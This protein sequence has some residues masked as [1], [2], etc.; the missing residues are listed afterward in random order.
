MRVLVSDALSEQ[1]LAI[2][3]QTPG[4]TID[5]RPG[6]KEAELAEAIAGA[7]G[8]VIRSGSKVTARVIAAADQLKVIGRAGIGVDNV[9]VPAASK[10]GIVVMNTPT[11]NAV[12]TAEHA[13]ALLM[14][15]A[16]HVPQASALLKAGKWE[17][18]KFEGRELAGK[19]LGVV[20]LG[21]IGRIVADR[22]R[23]LS[24]KVIGFDPMVTADRAAQLGVELCSLDDIFARADAI[25]VHT[26]LTAQTRGLVNEEMLPRLKKG[27]LLV[28]AARGGIYDEAALLK[29]L[30]SGQI[31]GVALDVFV[32]EPPPAD[33]P[34]LLHDRVIA[35]PHLGAST[36]EAQDRVALEIAE[37]VVMYLTTGEIKNAVNTPSVAGEIALKQKPYLDLAERLGSFLAQVEPSLSPQA[38]EVECS[39]Q[40]AELGMKGISAAAVAGCLTRYLESAMNRVSAPVAAK[41]RGI[42]VR[43]LAS[44]APNEKYASLVVLRVIAADGTAHSVA[45]ALGTD[46]SPRL[47][48][49]DDSEVEAHL[50]GPTLVIRS[51]NKPGVIGFIGT[52]LGAASVNVSRVHLGVASS[53]GAVSVW[54]LDT[55]APASAVDEL[56]RSPNVRS[57]VA[58]RV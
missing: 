7:D 42:T 6:L 1:G 41:E 33:H 4:A 58:I 45:G 32:E 16:R 8:L 20:G 27:V 11:G 23:G 14:A 53:E 49:W 36:K 43:E 44:S 17:K 35:T 10:R 9:D 18:K 19:T 54:N 15:L 34:L 25:T 3:R 40:P 38:V 37:Q 47:L 29:G 39:G 5:Y 51:V 56:R 2:L 31:G 46:G 21:N 28:N 24:M 52:T 13:I 26:P 50:G 30:E 22:A 48:R 12:T 55:D 57:A